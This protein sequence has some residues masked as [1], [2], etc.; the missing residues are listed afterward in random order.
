MVIAV[1]VLVLALLSGE[2]QPPIDKRASARVALLVQAAVALTLVI[3]QERIHL[4]ALDRQ[5]LTT[6]AVMGTWIA[7]RGSASALGLSELSLATL[8]K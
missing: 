4:L 2:G 3:S 8:A 6:L 7:R 1:L 5:R